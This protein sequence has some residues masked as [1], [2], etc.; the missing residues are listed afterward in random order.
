[1]FH[2]SDEHAEILLQYFQALGEKYLELLNDTEKNIAID[3]LICWKQNVYNKSL[4]EFKN[5]FQNYWT[6]ILEIKSNKKIE[7]VYLFFRLN[8]TSA[9]I[10]HHL[11]INA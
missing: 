3:L 6:L 8:I 1:M 9:Y 11:M 5:N 10:L 2:V 7:S 4:D